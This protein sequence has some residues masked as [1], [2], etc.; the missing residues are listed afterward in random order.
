MPTASH[1]LRHA[2]TTCRAAFFMAGAFSM[3]INLLM[4]VSPIYMMQV[5]NRVL[6][7]RSVETLIVLSALAFALLA[8][9]GLLD[10]VRSRILVRVSGKL[11][12]RLSER[13][14]SAVFSA[15]LHRQSR[16]ASQGMRDFETLRQ[17][18]SGPMLIAAFD[19]PW[20]PVLILIVFAM[21]PWLGVLAFAGALVLF[22]LAMVSEMAT[23]GALEDASAH[24]IR[25]A[26]TLDGGLRNAEV[27]QAMGMLAN[28]RRRWF[29]HRGKML[30]LQARASDLGGTLNAAS[31]FAR[32]LLQ[33]ALLGLGA[34][35][36]IY[37][38]ITPGA[39][40]AASIIMGRALAPVESAIGGWKQF[41]AARS[42]YRRLSGLLGVEPET[43]AKTSLPAPK[44]EIRFENVVVVPPGGG[45]P[46][47][48]GVNFTIP[49]GQ[50][51]CILGPSGAG[52]STLARTLVG[53][54]R[55]Y[56][57]HVRIDGA[58]IHDWNR[59]ELGP[60][61]GYLPQ[62]VELFDG[63][64]A[65]NIARFGVA[66]SSKIVAAAQLAGVHETILRLSQGYETAI[67]PGG[68]TLSAGQRQ[69]IGLARALYGN[70]AIVVLDEPNSNLD[71]AGEMALARAVGELK[72]RGAT[73]LLI[74]HRWSSRGA[75]DQILVIENGAI[76]MF[77]PRNEV[78]QRLVRPA[79]VAAAG[80]Q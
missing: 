10:I 44:G 63:T 7:S 59:S 55:P 71:E 14:F 62:D 27:V 48:R 22:G 11:D 49:A 72:S 61:I 67:G 76:R 30:A 47:L 79:A 36:A 41:V 12:G 34:Y 64:V 21:H 25:F 80:G 65:E 6:P 60:H 54:W 42:S 37:D 16:H 23:R 50:V 18:I 20:T 19:A 45:A 66:D 57:G 33:T 75:L 5:Y 74:S 56:S 58:S 13:I 2:L 9:M 73:V 29:S 43:G 31:K 39:I 46:T 17:F 15:T 26:S 69:R 35:L 32:L 4:L 77:G 28:L 51:L 8:V 3:F 40:I 70:P 38:E 24:A 1:E 78:V 52:K 68:S 53:A